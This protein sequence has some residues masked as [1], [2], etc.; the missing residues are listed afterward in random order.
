MEPPAAAKA[1]IHK[2]TSMAWLTQPDTIFRISLLLVIALYLRTLKF[3][4]VYDD[5]LIPLNPWIQSWHGVLSAFKSDIWG[6]DTQQGTSYYRPIPSALGVVIAQLTPGTPGWFHFTALVIELVLCVACYAFTRKIFRDD[7]LAAFTTLLFALHPTK[8]ESVAWIGSAECDGQ[9]AIYLF[10]SFTCY[11]HWREERKPAWLAASLGLF[12][13]AVFT[14]ETMIAIPVLI[15]LHFWITSERSARLRSTLTLML[16]YAAIAFGFLL[17]RKTVLRPVAASRNAVQASFSLVNV[18]SAPAAFWWYVKRLF[19]PFGLSILYDPL[20]VRRAASVQF[21]L[22]LFGLMCVAGCIFWVWQRTRA[23]QII[24]WSAWFVLTLG[25]AVILSPQ[26]TVHDRYLQLAAL[27]FCAAIAWGLLKIA[28]EYGSWR[29]VAFCGAVLLVSAWSVSTWHESGFWDNNLLLWQRAVQ[30]APRN[31]NARVELARL[32]SGSDPHESIAVLDDG[33]RILPQS[34]GLWRTRGLLLFN[35]GAYEDAKSSLLKAV[36]ASSQFTKEMGTEPPDV[37][38]GRA[39]AAF[40]LGQIEMVDGN[41]QA[42]DPWLRMATSIQ[43]DNVDYARVLLKNLR[44]EGLEGEADAYEKT[45]DDLM[46]R[47]RKK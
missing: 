6:F 31:V 12:A 44:A 47:S 13:L 32:Y 46:A 36:E 22:P 27:P 39:A 2:P 25:P 43:P 38:Y 11:L 4:F 40:A 10:S 18:W 3:D 23:W 24:F 30:I 35:A 1:A 7:T 21:L 45:V 9:A 34:P 42:A 19:F 8:V 33:L 37:R 5:L 41:P 26:V 15:A 20:T 29:W 17:V 16:P 28:R 14:K